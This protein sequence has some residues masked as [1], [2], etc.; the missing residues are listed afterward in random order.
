MGTFLKKAIFLIGII[1]F[2]T[3]LPYA[4]GKK[5]KV[6][7][8]KCEEPKIF[9]ENLD[10][11][12]IMGQKVWYFPLLSKQDLVRQSSDILK[13]KLEEVSGTQDLTKACVQARWEGM[14]PVITGFG[15]KKVSYD[16]NP[17]DWSN[18]NI[19]GYEKAW[20][21][22]QS[23]TL[24]I[25]QTDNKNYVFFVRCWQDGERTWN[26]M[27][28]EKNPSEKVRSKILEHAKQLGFA[29]DDVETL[30]YEGCDQ[31]KTEL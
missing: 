1:S 2:L 11:D 19:L 29:N 3:L 17:L 4:V 14:T 20:K 30:D 12:W 7:V 18:F 9:A 10:Y 27:A 21:R 23:G 6:P 15:G 26:V 22:G 24:Y 28:T 31:Q 25:T 13:K 16:L 5:D 8:K